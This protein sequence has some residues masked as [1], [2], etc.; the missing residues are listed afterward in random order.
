MLILYGVLTKLNIR[1]RSWHAIAGVLP[2]AV[3]KV[4]PCY[5]RNDKVVV[6]VRFTMTTILL[7]GA[8]DTGRAPMAAALLRRLLAAQNSAWVVESAGVLGHDGAPAEIEARDTM[9]HMA[10]DISAHQ[11]RSMTDELVEAAALIVTIDSGTALVVRARYPNAAARVYALGELA[12]RKRDVPDPFR[13]QIGAWMTYAREIEGM[14]HAALPKMV[15]LVGPV[16]PQSS[17][18]PSPRVVAESFAPP[19]PAVTGSDSSAI[20]RSAAAGRIA[21]LLQVA[22]QMPGVVDWGVARGRVESDLST[23]AAAPAGPTDLVAAYIGLLRAALA[24][25][26]PTPSGAQLGA[27]Q[28]AA[29]RVVAPIDQAALNELSA[30]LPTLPTLI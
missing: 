17:S 28:R 14:L 16:S 2:H 19:L 5:N 26:P 9:V 4:R 11:A 30:Q 10:L 7:V 8:A 21:Q 12:G 22:A 25:L 1:Q 6:R 27:L 24:L 18:A 15:E 13:M 29:E 23:I 20:E 3:P